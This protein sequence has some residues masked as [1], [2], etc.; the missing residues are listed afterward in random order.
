M[1]RLTEEFKK[2]QKE[3][4]ETCYMVVLILYMNLIDC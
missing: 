3:F 4:R 1:I 2:K